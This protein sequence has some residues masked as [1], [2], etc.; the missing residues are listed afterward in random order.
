MKRGKWERLVWGTLVMLKNKQWRYNQ[1]DG[2]NKSR[3][4]NGNG[5]FDCY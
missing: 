1:E 4:D 5:I 2:W 3:G